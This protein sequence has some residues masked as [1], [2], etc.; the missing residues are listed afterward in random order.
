[1]LYIRIH[2]DKTTKVTMLCIRNKFSRM[3]MI[4]LPQLELMATL[5][6]VGLLRYVCSN[7]SFDRYV[8]ILESDSTVVLNW[9]PGDPNQRKT[10][11]CNRTTKILNYTTPLQ[12]QH[13]SGSQNQADCISQSISPIDLYSLD[14]WWNGPVW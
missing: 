5:I 2:K 8:S 4:P 3:K 7:T 13:C 11:V 6:G 10:F 12:W 14:I 1:M 9:I